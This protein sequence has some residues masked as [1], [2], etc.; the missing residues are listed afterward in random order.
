M[1]SRYSYSKRA[2]RDL[3]NIYIDT[4]K[5]WGI[6]QADKYAAGLENTVTL[7]AKNPDMGRRC[8]EIKTGYQRFEHERHIIFYRKR[9]TDILILRILHD[10]MD[11]KRHA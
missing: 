8:D 7:L 11:A 2:E 6:A 4:A 9:K 1:T 10:R 5:E 3:K